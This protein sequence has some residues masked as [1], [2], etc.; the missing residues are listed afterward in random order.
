MIPNT[1]RI[2]KLCSEAVEFDIAIMLIYSNYYN[3]KLSICTE[4]DQIILNVNN[5]C[6]YNHV[7]TRP[8][9]VF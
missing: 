6:M 8:N 2:K 3:T 5:N 1:N 4:L 9:R 7:N